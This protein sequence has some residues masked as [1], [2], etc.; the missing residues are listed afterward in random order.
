SREKAVQDRAEEK[1]A[2]VDDEAVSPRAVARVSTIVCSKCHYGAAEHSRIWYGLP[3]GD[4]DPCTDTEDCPLRGHQ[5]AKWRR[6]HGPE[7]TEIVR[8]ARDQKKLRSQQ[9]E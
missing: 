1:A 7:A 3:K 4:C 2:A 9:E 8:L 6:Y 5:D